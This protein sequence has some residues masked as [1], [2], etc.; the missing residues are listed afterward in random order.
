MLGLFPRIETMPHRQMVATQLFLLQST[1][2]FFTFLLALVMT[3]PY[4]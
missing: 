2:I 3:V 4:S 1:I